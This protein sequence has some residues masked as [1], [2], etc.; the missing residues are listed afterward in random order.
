MDC[1][2]A[3]SS[4]HGNFQ[5]RILERAAIS[6][7]RGSSPPRDQTWVSCIAGRFFTTEPP[8]KP[9][10]FIW[11]LC[12]ILM[13]IWYYFNYCSLTIYFEIRKYG[14]YFSGLLW[15]FGVFNLLQLLCDLICVLSWSMFSVHSRRMWVLLHLYNNYCI[16][17]LCHFNL[18]CSH[19]SC[20]LLDFLSGCSIH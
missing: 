9:H 11:Y 14:F 13:P 16:F 20:F 7:S 18:L 3:G 17:M 4:A 6:F 2:P 19:I 15:L 1:S 12:L 10:G 8:G 5:A